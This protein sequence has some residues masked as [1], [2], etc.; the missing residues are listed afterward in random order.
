MNRLEGS[1]STKLYLVVD[2]KHWRV[3]NADFQ[4]FKPII[5]SLGASGAQSRYFVSQEGTHRVYRFKKNEYV[6]V[7]HGCCTG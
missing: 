6:K 1:P 4:N 2:D 7:I 3:H 5:R